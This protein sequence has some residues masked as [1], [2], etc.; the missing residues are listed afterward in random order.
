[1]RHNLERRGYAF[2]LRPVEMGDADFTVKLRADSSRSPFL[3]S[4]H[5]GVKEQEAYLQRYFERDNDYYFAIERLSTGEREGMIGIYDVRPG[6]TAEWGRWI[7][8]PGSLGAVESVLLIYDLG[9]SS[10]DLRELY[11][12][13][14]VENLRVVS[15]HDSCG[16]VRRR[17]LPSLYEIAGTRFDAVEHVMTRE[18]WPAVERDLRDK[19]QAIAAHIR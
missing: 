5:G 1:M 2:R 3:P 15:F 8:R 10:L 18:E 14:I 17:V 13:T 9:F 4:I 11:C 6:E 19:A 12:H 16:L 7:L